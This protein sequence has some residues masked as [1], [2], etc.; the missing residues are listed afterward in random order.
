MKEAVIFP[1]S[2]LELSV[3]A[4]GLPDGV[5]GWTAESARRAVE[6]LRG[7]K[8][9]VTEVYVYDRVVWGF[10][11]AG[12]TW[13]CYRFPGELSSEFADR[14]RH[15]ALDWIAAFP[16]YGVLFTI[17]FSTQDVAAEA[18]ASKS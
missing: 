13:A 5:R 8:V 6:S 14:S 11:P 18:T 15:E 1:R 2:I 7:S 10:A 9:A 4:P 12:E 17:E 16:R 3:A